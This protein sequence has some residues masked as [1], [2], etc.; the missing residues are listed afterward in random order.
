[1]RRVDARHTPL[2]EGMSAED[3]ARALSI[4]SAFE[5]RYTK[6]EFL[7]RLNEPLSHFGLVLSGTVQVGMDDI[8]G[9]PI[10]MA[11][12]EPGGMFGESLCL[13]KREACVSIRAVT[14][15]EILWMSARALQKGGALTPLEAEVTNRLL[16]ILA[17]RTLSMNDRVQILSRTHLRDRVKVFLSQYEQRFGPK[18]EIPFSRTDFAV[19]LGANRSALSRE[20]KRMRD[21]GMIQY[22]KRTFE[23][24]SKS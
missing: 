21:E 19:Y 18:F 2:F 7:N 13:L 4:L 1:M 5:K 15:C 22:E 6:G 20:L 10:L 12:V 8:D 24:L 9:Y 11:H 23:I 16:S 14:P 3:Y 17:R